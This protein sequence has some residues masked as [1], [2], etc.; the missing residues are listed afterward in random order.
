[1]FFIDLSKTLFIEI[2]IRLICLVRNSE[3]SC[4]QYL[5]SE[6]VNFIINLRA[7]FCTEVFLRSFFSTLKFLSTEY[8]S[9]CC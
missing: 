6:G 3:E 9:K 5:G 8:W 2:S 4:L 7:A 1:M